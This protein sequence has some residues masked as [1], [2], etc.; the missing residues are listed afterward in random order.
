MRTQVVSERGGSLF[1]KHTTANTITNMHINTCKNT[2]RI[3]NAM[4][5]NAGGNRGALP[6]PVGKKRF[7]HVLQMQYSYKYKHIEIHIPNPIRKKRFQLVLQTYPC[8]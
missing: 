2:N 8:K 1:R 7:Q 6:D 3:T 4:N 5:E